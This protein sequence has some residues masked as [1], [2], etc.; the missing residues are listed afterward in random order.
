MFSRDFI[1]N[2]FGWKV[3]S[4]LLATLVWFTIKGV[5]QNDS[6]DLPGASASVVRIFTA[7]P[8]KLLVD[9]SETRRFT[10]SPSAVTVT[11]R[12]HPSILESLS[13]EQVHAFVDV[14]D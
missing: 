4:L 1:K 12:G 6:P 10:I 2:N 3:A 5:I 9:A 13:R 8:I 7:L 11:L 14:S